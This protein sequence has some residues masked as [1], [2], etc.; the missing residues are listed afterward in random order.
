M[1]IFFVLSYAT[2]MHPLAAKAFLRSTR[3]E[4]DEQEEDREYSRLRTVD[5][6]ALRRDGCDIAQTLPGPGALLQSPLGATTHLPLP[7]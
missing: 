1:L 3:L 4:V 2:L 5:M 7:L 6:V